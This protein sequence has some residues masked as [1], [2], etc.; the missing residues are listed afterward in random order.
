MLKANLKDVGSK[1]DRKRNSQA[2]AAI[3]SFAW[4]RRKEPKEEYYCC[5][6]RY[7]IY[8]IYNTKSVLYRNMYII[9]NTY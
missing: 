6:W 7:L 1:M 4:Q 5:F 2:N 8:I 3:A 9:Y